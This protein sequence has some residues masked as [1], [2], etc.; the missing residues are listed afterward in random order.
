MK[1]LT[2]KSGSIILIIY[3]LILN[4]SSCTPILRNLV[5]G[6]ASMYKKEVITLELDN[7]KV[8][9]IARKKVATKHNDLIIFMGVTTFEKTYTN[10]YPYLEDMNIFVVHTP[11]HGYDDEMTTGE[12]IKNADDLTN[13]QVKV[14]KSLISNGYTTPKVNILGYSMGGMTLIN[15]LNRHL[16]DSEIAHSILVSTNRLSG[17][18]N[19]VNKANTFNKIITENKYDPKFLLDN[20]YSED[21][22]F[23]VRIINP[24]VF[25][26]T[27]SASLADFHTAK[28]FERVAQAEP[29]KKIDKKV[30]Y[31]SGAKDKIFAWSDIRRFS[32]NF[33]DITLEKL[34]SGHLAFLER[35]WI[36]GKIIMNY[37]KKN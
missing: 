11:L 19:D 28:D 2:K 27:D 8:K 18:L 7:R 6:S 21:T 23:Y 34:E 13:F 17:V 31:L 20:C 32:K 1:K 29:M 12:A 26:T 33:N 25:S 16:L 10:L 9:V 35:P 22:P 30:L 24:E 5:E 15:I 37:L 4:I 14:V 36:S 3:L